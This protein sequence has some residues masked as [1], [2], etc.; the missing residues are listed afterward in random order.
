[1]DIVKISKSIVLKQR[2][3][4]KTLHFKGLFDFYID[5]I[6]DIFIIKTNET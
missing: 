2:R 1:M 4:K 3:N 5:D 6:V